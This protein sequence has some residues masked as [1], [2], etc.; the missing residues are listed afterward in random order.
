MIH[1]RVKDI[2][3]LLARPLTIPNYYRRRYVSRFG[4]NGKP[5]WLHLGSGDH[6]LRGFVNI[7]GNIRKK[8]DLWL[9]VRNGL[10]FADGAVDAIYTVELFEHL[11]SDELSAVLRE[12]ARVLKPGGGI[13]IGVPNL[14]SAIDAY[15]AGR[16]E[17]Y[18]D[19]PRSHSSIGG[20][21]VNFI[22]CDGQHRTAFDFEFMAE[23]VADAGFP[24]VEERRPAASDVFS[25]EIVGPLEGEADPRLPR[26]LYVEAFK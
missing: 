6:C 18:G 14:R 25:A 26:R 12:C 20:R 10:P 3:F 2:Y 9:D 4:G 13:R 17:W 11:F 15:A 7:E 21:F 5:L 23:M 16:R 19:W 22:F 8:S 1:Q 24:K